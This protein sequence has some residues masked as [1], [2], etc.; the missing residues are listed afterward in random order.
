MIAKNTVISHVKELVNGVTFKQY[1]QEAK[2]NDN[3]RVNGAPHIS[4]SEPNTG[5]VYMY[6]IN[7]TQDLKSVKIVEN[8]G[9]MRTEYGFI[10]LSDLTKKP[11]KRVTR[12]A[13]ATKATRSTN[14]D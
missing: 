8:D 9:I 10:P 14:K 2:L 7:L 3:I 6:T 13:K 12:K 11:A 4:L 5:K 1:A